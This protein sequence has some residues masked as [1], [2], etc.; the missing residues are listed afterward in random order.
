SSRTEL[1]FSRQ[2][3]DYKNATTTGNVNMDYIQM[4]QLMSINI[5]KYFSLM[6]GAQTSYLISAQADSSTGTGSGPEKSIMD[7]YNRI[8]YGY[9][10]GVEIH[11]VLGL[12]IGARYNVSLAKVYK[13]LQNMQAPSFTSQDAKNNVIQISVGWRFGKQPKK[14]K[15][16]D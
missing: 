5:T 3:Y 1:I 12:I 16:E 9:A 15:K 8:D 10:V 4:G 11:P 2:G 14:E 13:D 7:L 6:L